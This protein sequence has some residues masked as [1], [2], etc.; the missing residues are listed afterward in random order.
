MVVRL[1]LLRLHGW[2]THIDEAGFER[3]RERPELLV[4]NA[5]RAVFMDNRRFFATGGVVQWSSLLDDDNLARYHVRVA[6]LA[7]PDLAEWAHH[8]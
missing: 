5:S 3:M 2:P 1:G 8:P 7:P 6:E 4:P